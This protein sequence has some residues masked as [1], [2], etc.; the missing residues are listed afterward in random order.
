[1]GIYSRWRLVLFHAVRLVTK[2]PVVLAKISGY[3]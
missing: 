3:G 1:M 2:V